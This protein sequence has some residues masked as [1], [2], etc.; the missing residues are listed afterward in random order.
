MY[1]PARVMSAGSGSFRGELALPK[2]R[3][4]RPL[5]GV[6]GRRPKAGANGGAGEGPPPTP[7]Y[8]KGLLKGERER[9]ERYGR[10]DETRCPKIC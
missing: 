7:A 6:W 10:L 5:S 8:L 2:L 4:R 3:A 1:Y 9:T